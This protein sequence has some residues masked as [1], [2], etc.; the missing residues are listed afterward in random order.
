MHCIGPAVEA[1]ILTLCMLYGLRLPA[2]CATVFVF[3]YLYSAI[4]A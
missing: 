3:V 1:A 2:Q 4:P